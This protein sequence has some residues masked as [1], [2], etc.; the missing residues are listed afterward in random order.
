VRAW[1]GQHEYDVL[2][3]RV[4]HRLKPVATLV[5]ASAWEDDCARR[6]LATVSGVNEWGVAVLVLTAQPDATLME[7]LLQREP[8]EQT[9]VAHHVKD[10]QPQLSDRT[11]SRYVSAGGFGFDISSASS[12]V[13]V[14]ES[15]LLLGYPLEVAG[16]CTSLSWPQWRV[17]VSSL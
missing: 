8:A 10:A 4:A 15:A 7:I 1:R 3:E 5:N 17:H 9:L 11:V 16:A 14:L 6:C 12:P 2:V 13:N